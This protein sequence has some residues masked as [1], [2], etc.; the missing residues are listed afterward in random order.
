MSLSSRHSGND[1]A[2]LWRQAAKSGLA[3]WDAEF[4]GELLDRWRAP[5]TEALHSSRFSPRELAVLSTG[6]TAVARCDESFIEQD[7][8]HALRSG[9]NV[10]ELIEM[11]MHASYLDR[12]A[13]GL[14]RGLGAIQRVVDGLDDTGIGYSITGEGLTKDDFIIE[15]TSQ[16]VRV[17]RVPLQRFHPALYSAYEAWNAARFASRTELTRRMQELAYIATDVAVMWP[18]PYLDRHFVIAGEMG[19]V[20][21][22]IAELIAFTAFT[23]S[24]REHAGDG[25]GA[26]HA[27]LRILQH[28]IA[29]LDRNQDRSLGLVNR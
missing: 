13:H 6:L 28:G 19:I 17:S 29:A 26:V 15:E 4:N 9:S 12:G 22:E 5:L 11:V 2:Y 8:R 14:H 7:A 1:P 21:Q 16:P 23:V 27:G 24:Q 3:I 18:S 20:S 10:V 25:D